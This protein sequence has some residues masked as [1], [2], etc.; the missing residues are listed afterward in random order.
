MWS[1]SSIQSSGLIEGNVPEAVGRVGR[2]CGWL[3]ELRVVV[4][5]LDWSET[6]TEVCGV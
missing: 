1:S 5:L 4:A 3:S 6:K 2:W